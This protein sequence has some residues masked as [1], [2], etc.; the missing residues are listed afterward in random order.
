MNE[1]IT[2]R[3]MLQACGKGEIRKQ[4]RSGNKEEQ[5]GDRRSFLGTGVPGYGGCRWHWRRQGSQM[6]W[7]AVAGDIIL[8][9]ALLRNPFTF[10]EHDVC[11]PEPRNR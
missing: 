5:N 4:D 7:P 8:I 1:E 2:L 11:G 10:T 9:T 3:A 6:E